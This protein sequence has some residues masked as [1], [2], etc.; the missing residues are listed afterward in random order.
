MVDRL[1][2]TAVSALD[3]ESSRRSFLSRVA[4]FGSAFAVAPLRYLLRPE[5]AQ[6]VVTCGD[7]APRNLCCDGWTT[8]CCTI[9]DGVNAC[10]P[11]SFIAGWWKCT[12]YKGSRLCADEGVRYYIDCNRKP[13]HK[14]PSGCQCANGKCKN[15]KTCCI[16]FRYGQCNTDVAATNEVVC[17]VVM[18]VNPCSVYSFCDCTEKVSNE[19]CRHE[20]ACF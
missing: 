10:P 7:C 15:R 5:T 19:T 12:S 18:C 6:A 14:C 1:V 2:G 11:Y 4:L 3:R 9:N 8:F 17:R 20:A 13:R 16:N